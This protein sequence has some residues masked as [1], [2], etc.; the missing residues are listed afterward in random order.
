VAHPV[1][2]GPVASQQLIDE[3]AAQDRRLFE[4]VFDR[5]DADELATMLADDFEFYHDKSGLVAST[6]QQFVDNVRRGCEAQ[7]KGTNVR[8]RREAV[9]GTMVVYE[10]KDYGAIQTGSHRFYGIEAGK[11]DVLRETGRLFHLWRREAGDWKLA[12][13]FSYDHRPAE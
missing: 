7:A 2:A 1:R 4:L 13:V 9:E 6:P 3:I 12:R 5:C 11:P 10:I 8:A